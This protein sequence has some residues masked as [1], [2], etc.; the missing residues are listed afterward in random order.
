MILNMGAT[1]FV[2]VCV[3]TLNPSQQFFIHVRTISGIP[4]MKEY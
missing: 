1:Y 4:G 2:F 3:D